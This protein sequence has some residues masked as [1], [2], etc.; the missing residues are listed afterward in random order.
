MAAAAIKKIDMV[1]G[2]F[3]K[4]DLFLYRSRPPK[5]IVV[6]ITYDPLVSNLIGLF[7]K[8]F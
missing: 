2:H 5:K 4:F 3:F 1:G 6:T 7:S 8:Y